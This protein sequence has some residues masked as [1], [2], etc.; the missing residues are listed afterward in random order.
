MVE[1]TAYDLTIT[2]NDVDA[3]IYIPHNSMS[4]ELYPRQVSTF[5]FR[6]ENP[7]GVTPS[8]NHEIVVTAN[9]LAGTPVVFLGYIR[10]VKTTKFGNGISVFY[11]CEAADRK[12]LLQRS[13][14]DTDYLTGTDTSI[15]SAL[16]TNG[17]PDLSSY[18]NFSDNVTGFADGLNLPVGNS[19]IMEAL[20]ALSEL[21]GGEYSFD[22][23]ASNGI[24]SISFSGG[25]DIAISGTT[26]PYITGAYLGSNTF[27]PAA[28]I[29]G[30]VGNPG[31][32]LYLQ[33]TSGSNLGPTSALSFHSY[34]Y[35][36]PANAELSNI[37]FDYYI[38][39]DITTAT[40]VVTV[41]DTSSSTTSYT[42]SSPTTGSW[43]S[44]DVNADG[45]S[46]LF[47]E[48]IGRTAAGLVPEIVIE[49]KIGA[50]YDA[51]VSTV[52]MRLD[53]V[54]FTLNPAFGG[55]GNSS[56]LNWGD[57]APDAD[58]NFNID[59]SDEFG[60]NF[61][62]TEGDFDDYNSVTV[63]GGN[64][65][66]AIDWTYPNQD[67]Q[68]HINIETDV[69]DI[70]VYKNTGSEGTPTWTSQTVGVYGEDDISSV[71]VLYNK[72]NHWLLFATAPPNYYDAVR[73]TGTIL[74]PIR[75]RVEDVQGSDPTYATVVENSS[76]TSVDQALALG[77]SKLKKRN[78]VKNLTFKTYEPGL[79]PGQKISITDSG[80][81]LAETLVIQRISVRWVGGDKALFTVE[82]GTDESIGIDTIV[83]NND[84][85]SRDNQLAAGA[86]VRTYTSITDADDN[87]LTDAFGRIVYGIKSA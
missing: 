81:G 15:L 12:I 69:S 58:F 30:S 37:T 21:T 64:T 40:I 67:S 85:R 63:V 51:S 2:I 42:F 31:A 3:T 19:S 75:V 9:S 22:N 28:A 72:L 84:K 14:I 13:V 5:R 60:F 82:C 49:F 44:V 11:E 24:D 27:S 8:R 41:Y 20:E 56:A 61:D 47:P 68:V 79:V 23:I 52:D 1:P 48:T 38:G 77:N 65:E 43:Q 78:A 83:A 57:T 26:K 29:G 73:I 55:N 45:G 32:S 62:F 53:N 80:R 86:V 39:T 87:T 46:A 7:S 50:V 25:D 74:T 35:T 34:L 66:D 36:P 17:Y 54:A 71:D 59:S 70:V 6:V 10:E 33:P 16:L 18:F 4:M 76:I